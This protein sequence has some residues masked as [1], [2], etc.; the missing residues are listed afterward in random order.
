MAPSGALRGRL[1][2]PGDKSISHRALL[3]AARAE[4]RSRLSGLSVGDDVIRTARAILALGAGLETSFDVAPD[5]VDQVGSDGT[6]GWGAIVSGGLS[7]LH[8]PAQVIDVGNSGTAI[9]LLAGYVAGLD[10]LSVLTGDESVRSRPMDRVVGPLR[11]MGAV[12]DGRRGGHLAPLCVRGGSVVGI[13]Y[14]LPVASA[15]VKSA[16]LLAALG[17][18]GE[19]VVREPVPTRTHTEEML[20]AADA[21]IEVSEE[22]S[23]RVIRIRPGRLRA[24]DLAV[25]GDPSQ[26]AFWV[27]AG[28]VV[29]GSE[30]TVERVYVGAGRAG[31]LAVLSRMGA[32]LH[33]R[34]NGDATADITARHCALVGTTVSED[35]VPSLVDEIPVLAVAGAF[36]RGTTEFSGAG[37]LRFKESDRVATTVAGLKELGAQVRARP[38]GLIVNGSAGSP[39]SGGHVDASGDHRIAM[40]M[41]IAALVAT[42]P[43]TIAGWGAV[44]TSYPGFVADRDRLVRS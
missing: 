16:I 17:A 3:L 20:R 7:Q 40:A 6:G 23:G 26:A 29:P 34:D 41:F 42:G 22:G 35:E 21:D 39:L 32:D 33:I 2:V 36:A 5:S 10:G 43:T 1:V 24:F 25:P 30:I 11:A 19:T 14:R 8:E 38:D 13:D 9:R 31:F 18:S 27:V 37:E 4:G 12:V 28:C 44:T 15:Q